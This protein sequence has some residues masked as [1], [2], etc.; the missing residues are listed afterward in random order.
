MIEVAQFL[1]NE[2]KRKSVESGFNI[3]LIKNNEMI[4]KLFNDDNIPLLL[5]LNES[6]EVS[7]LLPKNNFFIT[8]LQSVS[9]ILNFYGCIVARKR[10]SD[11]VLQ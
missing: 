9:F 10:Y 3:K 11:C 6:E 1:K 2:S 8:K 4:G 7:N 5:E